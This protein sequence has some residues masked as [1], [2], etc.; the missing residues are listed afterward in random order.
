MTTSRFSF[1]FSSCFLVCSTC[2]AAVLSPMEVVLHRLEE[3]ENRCKVLEDHCLNLQ[4]SLD[5]LR[6]Q[7]D[8]GKAFSEYEE[9]TDSQSFSVPPLHFS[10]EN[11]TLQ[12]V[13]RHLKKGETDQAITVLEHFIHQKNHPL[14]AQAL[15]YKGLIFMHQKKYD[16]AE[17]LFSTAYL[18]LKGQTFS[19]K[20]CTKEEQEKRKLFPIQIL[21]KSAECLHH[22]GKKSEAT[23]VCEEIKR[24]LIK[25]PKHH[26]AKIIKKL[27]AITQTQK[28][29]S[30]NK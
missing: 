3:L 21:L 16:Q 22:L 27:N 18:Y 4:Q 23:F 29:S 12:D 9:K 14:K 15:Y 10:S 26:H 7:K 19:S 13:T 11:K 8:D 5:T 30:K 6:A 1:I 24:H 17:T 25:I 28:K 20:L 2:V